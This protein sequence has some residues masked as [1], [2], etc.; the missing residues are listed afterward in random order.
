V[1]DVVTMKGNVAEVVLRDSECPDVVKTLGDGTDVSE[2]ALPFCD[3][4][5]DMFRSCTHI[6]KW[7]ENSM[8]CSCKC[9]E[10]TSLPCRHI[11]AVLTNMSTTGKWF[12]DEFPS[13]ISNT[14]LQAYEYRNQEQ[15]RQVFRDLDIAASIQTPCGIQTTSPSKSDLIERFM[16]VCFKVAPVLASNKST[17]ESTIEALSKIYVSKTGRSKSEVAILNPSKKKGNKESLV[18]KPFSTVLDSVKQAEALNMK[19]RL[20]KRRKS[21]GEF[22]RKGSTTK[23]QRKNPCPKKQYSK[24]GSIIKHSKRSSSKRPASSSGPGHGAKKTRRETDKPKTKFGSNS[25]R[26]TP[27]QTRSRTVRKK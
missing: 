21:F 7:A 22:K 3:H 15:Q 26:T 6:V 8:S 19:K 14:I 27:V 11:F 20:D 23:S 24:F 16:R 13:N 10:R 17:L 1:K 25:N 9:I 4:M 2:L 5:A 18:E 12:Q